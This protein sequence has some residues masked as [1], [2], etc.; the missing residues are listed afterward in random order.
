MESLI[1]HFKIVT[2]GYRVPPGEV[3]APIESARGEFGFYMISDGTANPWRARLRPPS[4]VTLASL[5]ALAT[6][7]YL[8]DLIA[9][10]ASIDPVMG[11]CDR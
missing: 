10:L 1:H 2:E 9:I 4:F 6:G 5:A 8:A 3:Y 7:H 11:D